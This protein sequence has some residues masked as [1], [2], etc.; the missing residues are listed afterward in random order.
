MFVIAI[1][2]H[3]W[4]AAPSIPS[5]NDVAEFPA[6]PLWTDAFMADTDHLTDAEAGFYIRLL[7]V[8]WRSPGQRIPDDKAWIARRFHKTLEEVETFVMPGIYEF[9]IRADGWITQKRLSREWQYVKG[10]SDKRSAA[11]KSRWNKDKNVSPAYA[12]K[13]DP[14]LSPAGA[15]TPTPTPPI[16]G[17]DSATVAT[18]NLVVK[19]SSLPLRANGKN[20]AN[21]FSEG[22]GKGSNGRYGDQT[23]RDDYAVQQCVPFLPGRDNEERW[24]IAMAAEDATMEGHVAAVRAMLAAA[25]KAKVG[26]VSPERR[27]H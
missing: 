18:P 12:Y 2:K 6:L 14:G 10:T 25:K 17:S 8:L 15:P 4:T 5:A 11:A 26:W 27:K 22:S 7:M 23:Q 24:L 16:E 21:G 19:D 13:H 3:T 1:S 20:H 9:C